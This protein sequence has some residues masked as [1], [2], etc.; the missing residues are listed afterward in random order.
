MEK[1][2]GMSKILMQSVFHLKINPYAM[3]LLLFC[4]VLSP[5]SKSQPDHTPK[6]NTEPTFTVACYYFPN[7][8]P[9]DA[10]NNKQKGQAW[11]EW[12]LVKAARPRFPGHQQPK[13][14]LWGYTD[15]S[16]P[17]QMTQKIGAA[18]DHGIDAFIFDWYW[19]D[20]GPF[21]ERGLEE[22]FLKA[23]NND[24]LKFALMWA[25]HDWI[26]IHPYRKDAPQTLLY[27]GRVSPETFQTVCDYAIARY[28]KHPSYWT[29]DGCPYFSVY[30]LT[31]LIA[32]FGSIEKTRE[33]LDQFRQ[34]VQAAGFA[35]LHINAVLWGRTI[36]PGETLPIDPQILVQ[37]LGVDSVTSYVWI[38]HVGLPKMQTDFGDVQREYF[39]YWDRA[40]AMFDVP[41][42]P[43]ITMG[44]DSSP[45]ADQRDPYGHYGYPFMNMIA[46]NTPERFEAALRA[47]RKKLLEND[48][49][50]IL[51]INCW[52]EWTEGSYLEPDTL[53]GMAYL[54]AVKRVF[55]NK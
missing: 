37:K 9:S 24:R 39:T 33:G 14:P 11:T 20:D 34:K 26:D 43:N 23:K 6:Q 1:D 18:A 17:N 47:A 48:G 53:H 40:R 49:P 30:D 13:V 45:R 54:Q 8:H 50:F 4:G 27:P 28:F 3:A 5:M 19:Y 16:D 32:I 51:N 22:G 35:N 44:W 52:N 31:K 41:Y 42:Y 10:R 29:I 15:E 25:N 36:L 46:N 21:L 2:A 7:Y 12:Q 38:H 55:G